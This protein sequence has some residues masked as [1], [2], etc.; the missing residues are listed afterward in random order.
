M[1]GGDGFVSGCAYLLVLAVRG[2]DNV[3]Q[4]LVVHLDD[5]LQEVQVRLV[6]VVVRVGLVQVWD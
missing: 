1:G 3:G 6:V 4:V 2:G 5:I